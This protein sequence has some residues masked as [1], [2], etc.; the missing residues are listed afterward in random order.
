MELFQNQYYHIYNRT[1]NHEILFRNSSDY[2]KFLINYKKHIAPFVDT[3]GYCLMPTH[4]HFLFQVK[5]EDIF[6][7]KRDFGRCLSF[8]T[9]SINYKYNRHGSLFQQHSKAILVSD[10]TYLYALLTYIHQNPVRTGLVK[11]CEDWE[12]S[13]YRDLAGLRNGSIPNCDHVYQWFDSVEAFRRFSDNM[14]EKVKQ[15][16]WI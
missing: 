11:K 9:K 2:T 3:L 8:Y 7:F 6:Q 1:N 4:F 5:T 13:S 10:D 15:E 12:F 14:L 16:F